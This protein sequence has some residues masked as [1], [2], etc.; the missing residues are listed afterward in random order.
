MKKM[1]NIFLIGMLAVVAA[2]FVACDDDDENIVPATFELVSVESYDVAELNEKDCIVSAIEFAT[3]SNWRISSD[4]IWVLFSATENGE[5]FNDIYGVAGAHKVFMKITNDARTF[6]PASA[7][8]TVKYAD[9]E[10]VLETVNRLAKNH[11]SEIID[12]NGNAVEEIVINGTA[13]TTIEINANYSFGLKSYPEWL[14]EPVLY[15]DSYILSIKDEYVPYALSGNVVIASVDGSIEHTYPINYAGMSPTDIRISGDYTP[16]AWEVALDGKTFRHE[17]TSLEGETEEVVVENYIPY[18]IKCL[19]YDCKFV[20]VT[21]NSNGRLSVS[22]DSWLWA[23]QSVEDK[24]SVAVYAK[25]F[26]ATDARS[27]KGYLFALPAGVYDE[28]IAAVNSATDAIAFVD[29]HTDYVLVEAT[30]KDIFAPDGFIITDASGAAVE[31]G[32]EKDENLYIWVSSELS[33][34][35]VYSIT[36]INGVTYIVNTLITPEEGAPAFAI[37]D[38]DGTVPGRR[39]GSPTMSLNADGY[40]ELKLKVPAASSFTKPLILRLHRNN[41]NI[42]AL[43]IKPVNN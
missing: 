4:K 1:K 16:W 38:A 40:Y 11:S 31:C 22:S 37:Y 42:K 21:E 23:E 18:T 15:N 32:E 9:K 39:W 7:D 27:R 5:Y 12:E 2:A 26:A 8:V 33:V 14:S 19:N 10:L 13:S 43:I 28:F 41:V 30:Q 17:G 34:T 6:E 25:P 3:N 24:S 35:D 20:C 29:E 36:G